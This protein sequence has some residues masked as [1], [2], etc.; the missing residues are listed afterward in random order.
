MR[1]IVLSHTLK[2]L[3]G[4]WYAVEPQKRESSAEACLSFQFTYAHPE[5]APLTEKIR[6]LTDHVN[7]VSIVLSVTGFVNYNLQAVF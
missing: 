6:K 4:D 3:L 1:P 7:Y 5:M 2:S